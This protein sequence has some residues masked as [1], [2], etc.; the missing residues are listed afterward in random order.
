MGAG[1]QASRVRA[2]DFDAYAR[3]LCESIIV[4]SRRLF[5]SGAKALY[6]EYDLDN[7]WSSNFFCC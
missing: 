5:A 6:F 4:A 7:G 1:I 3:Q 2:L